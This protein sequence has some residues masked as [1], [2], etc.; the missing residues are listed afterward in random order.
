MILSANAIPTAWGFIILVLTLGILF[1]ALLS[2][3]ARWHR[4]GVKAYR[5]MLAGM[6][7]ASV[8]SLLIL[9]HL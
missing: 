3:G 6:A 5:A 8:L 7:L 2:G 4:A 1:T 9:L